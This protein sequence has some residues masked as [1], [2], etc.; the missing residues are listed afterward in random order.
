MTTQASVPQIFAA[1]GLTDKRLR[2]EVERSVPTVQRPLCLVY[3]SG[4]AHGADTAVLHQRLDNHLAQRW[5]EPDDGI[6]EIRGAR[7]HFVHSAVMASVALDT[8][9]SASNCGRRSTTRSAPRATTRC[10]T[11]T[12]DE[13]SPCLT[14][15]SRHD[16]SRSVTA[17]GGLRSTCVRCTVP[18]APWHF[19]CCC[20]PRY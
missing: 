13:V 16:R 3:D 14:V 12:T 10:A 7:R 4:V 20:L 11:P 19:P 17:D 2:E 8:A 18:A 1:H 15:C 5:R 6:W 9:P